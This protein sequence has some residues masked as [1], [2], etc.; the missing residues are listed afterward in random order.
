MRRN[1]A[2]ISYRRVDTT[3][4]NIYIR[5]TSSIPGHIYIYIYIE[6]IVRTLARLLLVPAPSRVCTSHIQAASSAIY[7]RHRSQP[8][9]C[10]FPWGE[11]RGIIGGVPLKV[12]LFCAFSSCPAFLPLFLLA[13]YVS[14]KGNGLDVVQRGGQKFNVARTMSI[15]QFISYEA[16]T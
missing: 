13:I 15:E 14:S 3:G 4:S 6:S 5:N 7:S 2:A 9:E 10:S 11:G 16:L 1:R 12:G 8:R